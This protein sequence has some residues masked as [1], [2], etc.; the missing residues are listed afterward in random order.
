M[1]ILTFD[2]E[3]FFD[4]KGGYS[5]RNMTTEAYCRDEKFICHG[6][7]LKWGDEPAQW[8]NEEQLEIVLANIDWNNTAVLAH[9]AQ[10]DLFI[11]KHIYDILPAFIFDTLSCAR[12]LLGNH[13]SVSLDSLAKHYALQAK[14]VPYNL[15]DGRHWDNLSP[16][17]QHDLAVGCCH[18]A[19]LTWQIFKILMKDMPREELSV[20]DTVIRMFVDPVL[21]G[22]TTM[23]AKV[24]ETESQKKEMRLEDLGVSKEQLM[25][26]DSFAD[27]LRAE[28][29][30][31][32]TKISPKGNE[33]YAFSKTDDFMRDY[34]RE[35]E[36][37][38]V[39]A[40]AEAR[41]GE[42][43]TLL[44]TRAAT[45][46]WMASRGPMPVYLRYS[47]AAT[48][49]FSGGDGANWQNF[50]R[51]SDIRRAICAPE[52]FLL[53]PIDLSQVECRCLG[54]LAGQEDQ[55]EKFRNGDDPYTDI[56][57]KFYGREITKSDAAERGT[58][59]Q[60]IL[61]CGYGS[62]GSKFQAT[63]KLGIY[64]PPVN[65]T[66]D[67]AKK[68]VELYRSTHHNVVQYWRSADWVL[69][70]MMNYRNFQWG[71]MEVRCDKGKET[72]R[73]YFPNGTC[74]IYDSLVWR[75]P[76]E[77]EAAQGRRAGYYIKTRYGWKSIYGSMLAQHMCEAVS[78][79]IMTQAMLRIKNNLK[80]RPVNSTHDELLVLIPK[81]GREEE[82][83]QLCI[84][85]MTCEPSWL[86]G[87][88]LDAEGALGSRYEK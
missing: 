34:L 67:E 50:K 22:D 57:A 62:A 80:L 77:N 56:A 5:L 55:I 16:Q 70:E 33:I 9:H 88:P 46:G 78:R 17:T 42:K 85:E 41:L 25:S 73:I 66:L 15:F 81:D 4:S 10:F 32:E 72:K 37:W 23:L 51:G 13:L 64:G 54:Y 75:Q 27:L 59:K 63:A 11:L 58:G 21:I 36:N 6:A 1:K 45:L 3:T 29:I 79:L 39:R 35:H 28:G 19:E 60:A 82:M 43:S 18:D 14:M 38:R 71:P 31:P 30:E 12:L 47:G 76:T 8:Y 26:A 24:W 68:F 20:I 44:Q 7:A 61:S 2:A 40:L 86:P 65:L 53:A 83:L 84:D 52:G 87:L 74:I 48:L 49:R 69:G